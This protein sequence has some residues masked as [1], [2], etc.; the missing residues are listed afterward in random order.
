MLTRK[1]RA[2]TTRLTQ[3]AYRRRHVRYCIRYQ[4]RRE[5]PEGP[6]SDWRSWRCFGSLPLLFHTAEEAHD[7][8]RMV[9]PFRNMRHLRKASCSVERVMLR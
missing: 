6:R 4:W 7:Y 8:L 2:A 3:A 1:Q 9:D 5:H